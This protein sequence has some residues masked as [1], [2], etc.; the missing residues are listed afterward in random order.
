[1]HN[2]SLLSKRHLLISSRRD[3]VGLLDLTVPSKKA[4]T[5]YHQVLLANDLSIERAVK[6]KSHFIYVIC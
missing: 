4:G 5:A 2:K 1:M 6:C 3:R